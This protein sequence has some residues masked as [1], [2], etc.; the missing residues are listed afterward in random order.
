MQQ[1]QC[2]AQQQQNV[3]G[4]SAVQEVFEEPPSRFTQSTLWDTSM[5]LTNATLGASVCW[6]GGWAKDST[7]CRAAEGTLHPAGG[8]Y[9][10]HLIP[11]ACPPPPQPAGAGMLAM[12]HAFAGLGVIGGC[13]SLLLHL[14]LLLMHPAILL[15]VLLL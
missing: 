12:P 7:P 10:G 11:P 5:N 3:A 9:D 4:W 14:L 13:A 15:A 1:Q 2:T 8:S 6:A